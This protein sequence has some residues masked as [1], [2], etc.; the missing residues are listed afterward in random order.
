[1]P[2]WRGLRRAERIGCGERILETGREF[3]MHAAIGGGR[4][5]RVFGMF[6]ERCRIKFFSHG[7]LFSKL[8]LSEPPD[9]LIVPSSP[10]YRHS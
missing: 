5:G 6:V 7:L 4:C 3:A 9:A 10:I 2:R 8:I 1:M